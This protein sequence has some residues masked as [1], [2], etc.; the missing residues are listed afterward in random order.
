M[1]NP[2]VNTKIQ[3]T[4]EGLNFSYTIS[5]NV[6]PVLFSNNGYTD[7]VTASGAADCGAVIYKVTD[8]TGAD[9]SKYMTFIVD[10]RMN[11]I[12]FAVS[13]TDAKLIGTHKFK[14][15]ATLQ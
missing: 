14:V 4:L 9:Y 10:G 6:V 1:H 7:L 15:R 5:Y 2:C 8:I 3:Q 13:T 11:K 12:T